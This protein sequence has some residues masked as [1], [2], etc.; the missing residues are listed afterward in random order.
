MPHFKALFT[1]KRS[2]KST[3][4]QPP[5][6]VP[7]RSYED[8]SEQYLR[9]GT[10]VDDD[11]Q[12]TFSEVASDNGGFS[13]GAAGDDEQ[14]SDADV[15]TLF[16]NTLHGTTSSTTVFSLRNELPTEQEDWKR[17]PIYASW[18]KTTHVY[19]N[20]RDRKTAKRLLKQRQKAAKEGQQPH[21]N[22]SEIEFLP[23]SLFCQRKLFY[24]PLKFSR[25][26]FMQ[27]YR[28]GRSMQLHSTRQC[29]TLLA[30]TALHNDPALLSDIALGADSVQTYEEQ[31][32]EPFAHVWETILRNGKIMYEI[33]FDRPEDFD[34][35]R[36]ELISDGFRQVT[37]T[38]YGGR[39]MQWT[40][41]TGLGS[42]FGSSLFCLRIGTEEENPQ[43][44]RDVPPYLNQP[45]AVYRYIETYQV[46]PVRKTGE[47]RLANSVFGFAD[48]VVA[49]GL[50]LRA[51]EV[52][53][54]MS[55]TGMG[56]F[57]GL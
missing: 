25:S 28:R 51:H 49:M 54:D 34:Q 36:V 22:L 7:L 41:T 14:D 23:P 57:R 30:S 19:E 31:G 11:V 46:M 33:E 15:R 52:R 29:K 18:L 50:V 32:S 45:V 2:K 16:Y 42:I 43:L 6:P 26:S 35:P 37:T 9:D 27:I 8:E 3:T 17:L 55:G 47:F 12:S 24:N 56:I 4:V 40:G 10:S 53:K 38:S 48:V 5:I 20:E 21:N 39:Q 1:K 44:N 13:P